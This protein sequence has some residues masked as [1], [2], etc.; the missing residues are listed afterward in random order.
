MEEVEV[1]QKFTKINQRSNELLCQFVAL[2]ACYQFSFSFAI[3]D[4]SSQKTLMLIL[5]NMRSRND[6]FSLELMNCEEILTFYCKH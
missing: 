2:S 6:C 1:K 5:L 3:F 4:G